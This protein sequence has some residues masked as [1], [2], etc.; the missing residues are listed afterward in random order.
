MNLLGFYLGYHDSNLC[1]VVDGVV[2]Y[3]K[4]E[5][6]SGVKHER[7]PLEAV[8]DTCEE[9][10]FKPEY[11]AYSDG[12]RNGLGS[13]RIGE[14]FR[15]SRIDLGLPSV[16]KAFCVDHHFSHILS[17]WP[18]A[19]GVTTSVGVALDGSGDNGVRARVVRMRNGAVVDSVFHSTEFGIGRF[20]TLTGRRLGFEGLDIDFAG[21]LMGAQ[22][23]GTPD[24]GFI[25]R[26]LGDDAEILPRRLLTEIPWR[27]CIP[28]S[29]NSFFRIENPDFLDWLSTC[30]SLL[31]RVLERFF[32]TFCSGDDVVIY[33]GGCAQNAVFNRALTRRFPRLI[34]PPH[35]YDGGQSLGCVEF[36]RRILDMPELSAP[37]F[38]FVQDDEWIAPPSMATVSKVASMLAEGAVVG[39]MVGNGEVGPRALGHRSIL[40]DPRSPRAKEMLNARVKFRESW[41]PYAASVLAER[42][43]DWFEVEKP[44]PYMIEAVQVRPDVSGQIPGVSHRD[45]S[46]RIQTVAEGTG[47]ESFRELLIRFGSLTGVPVLLNTSLNSSGEPIYG[48]VAQARKLLASG[49][50]DALCVGNRLLLR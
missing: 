31:C 20:F 45:G 4:F 16:R 33:S 22:A 19:P 11:V 8:R 12:D 15:E 7:V 44:S 35:A 21:K 5:R 26:H 34:I 30:H 46:C 6:R 37:N 9:W 28:G 39:W 18:C 10:G 49:R 3:R 38:P 50:L 25:D 47:P 29:D 23:Y 32:S 42:A 1:A 13:C 2:R 48:S 14:L 36:L 43:G 41:R 17:A 27:G 40:L 24:A